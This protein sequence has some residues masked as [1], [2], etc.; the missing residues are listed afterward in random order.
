[1][2][3]LTSSTQPSTTA[4]ARRHGDAGA[5]SEHLIEAGGALLDAARA[6]VADLDP[7]DS[8]RSAAAARRLVIAC[9]DLFLAAQEVE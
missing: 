9:A 8:P 5:A 3:K 2:Q 1:M 7:D 4:A 6:L